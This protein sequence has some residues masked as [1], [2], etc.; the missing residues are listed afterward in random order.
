MQQA[1]FKAKNVQITTKFSNEKPIN[2]FQSS[3]GQSDRSRAG[4]KF[5]V[6]GSG[7]IRKRSRSAS[8]SPRF[9][10][11][12]NSETEK[13]YSIRGGI[14]ENYLCLSFIQNNQTMPKQSLCAQSQGN[15]FTVNLVA[16]APDKAVADSGCEQAVSGVRWMSD[17]YEQ[18][19]DQD[20]D[21]V[22]ILPS[23]SS[24]KFGPGPLFMSQGVV[25]MPAYIAGFRKELAFDIVSAD[26][27]LLL[28]L[29]NLKSLD[30]TIQYSKLGTDT[31]THNGVKFELELTQGHHWLSLSKAGS[32]RSILSQEKGHSAAED[33]QVLSVIRSVNNE[34]KSSFLTK[35]SV[36][37]SDEK[38]CLQELRKVH[39]MQGHMS[40]SRLEAN[41]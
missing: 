6:K 38:S 41:L 11:F 18:L 3:T 28:S 21:D 16:S 17:Y 13:L 33:S 36:F 22:K 35:N 31:A 37:S 40:R 1:K 12:D 24:F 34:P 7:N 4:S 30:L 23:S 10:R 39:T 2:N 32:I 9:D 29:Q 15:T 5:P 26:I 25:I 27:P 20:K 8:T 14:V 19:S